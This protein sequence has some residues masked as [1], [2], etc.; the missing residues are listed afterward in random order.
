MI[1]LTNAML[2]LARHRP[3]FHSEA[4]FQHALAWQLQREHLDAHVRLEYRPFPDERIYLD[5]WCEVDGRPTAIELKYPTKRLSTAIGAERFE[6]AEHGAQDLTRY[7]IIKDVV[8]IERVV[9]SMPNS[10]G[11]VIVLTNDPSFW[12]ASKRATP[13]IDNAFRIHQGRTLAGTCEW[14][15]G[16]GPGTTKGRTTQLD[17]RGA[18]PVVWQDY[19]N[20]NE[21]WG[22]FKFAIF[23]PKPTTPSVP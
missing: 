14:G 11:A 15:L 2:R 10:A 16:A 5:I 9:D 7:D 4:D 3:V 20:T 19:W 1:D 13:T 6:V 12:N 17:V 18:Y 23:E 22:Q 8:R 21:R